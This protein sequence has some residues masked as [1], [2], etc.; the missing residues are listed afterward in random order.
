MDDVTKIENELKI[1]LD[2]ISK[3]KLPKT[4][5]FKEAQ[6]LRDRKPS[7]V[8]ISNG[9]QR[10]N[11][12][13]NIRVHPIPRIQVDRIRH[14]GNLTNDNLIFNSQTNEEL[15]MRFEN[16]QIDIMESFNNRPNIDKNT[17]YES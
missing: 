7:I 16:D 3:E 10:N 9:P 5:E 12:D 1:V 13:A 6:K 2:K 17:R 4:F 15:R 11:Y 14:S 8:S